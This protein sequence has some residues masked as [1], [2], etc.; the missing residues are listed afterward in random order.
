MDERTSSAASHGLD[1][2][3]ACAPSG[4]YPTFEFSG[5]HEGLSR[6]RLWIAVNGAVGLTLREA[7]DIASLEPHYLSRV[8]RRRV[9][10]TF[11][12]WTR[13]YRTIC[14]LRAIESCRYSIGEVSRLIA[15]RNRRTLERIIKAATGYTP[16]ELQRLS[17]DRN[18]SPGSGRVSR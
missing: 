5:V 1:Q 10:R 12:G 7:A 4:I 16:A 15:Y 9:G 14:A 17:R 18:R 2:E 13:Q 11:L 3:V 8:F 6:L